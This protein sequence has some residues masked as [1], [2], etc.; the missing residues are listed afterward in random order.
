MTETVDTHTVTCVASVHHNPIYATLLISGETPIGEDGS[1]SITLLPEA[2]VCDIKVWQL[3][4]RVCVIEYENNE[5]A[6]IRA[7][8]SDVSV[9]VSR[10]RPL[11]Y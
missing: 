2:G 5:P 3:D 8:K 6:R 10:F 1:F 9:Q 11:E 4:N 7:I